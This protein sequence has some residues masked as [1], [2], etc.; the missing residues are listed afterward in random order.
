ML[1]SLF[2]S[3]THSSQTH[4]AARKPAS[5]TALD[6]SLMLGTDQKKRILYSLLSVS[7]LLVTLFLFY[8]PS[9][10]PLHNPWWVEGKLGGKPLYRKKDYSFIIHFTRILNVWI[11][12]TGW[13]SLQCFDLW[14][15]FTHHQ[16]FFQVF[17]I[18]AFFWILLEGWLKAENH[19]ARAVWDTRTEG[20]SVGGVSAPHSHT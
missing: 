9:F 16:F 18:F 14:H 15:T 7:K 19:K 2:L 5:R 10:F 17:Y 11:S 3:H 1:L 20:K 13:V 4:T 12:L 8:N 6:V